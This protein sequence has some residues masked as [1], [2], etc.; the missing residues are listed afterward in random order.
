MIVK[1]NNNEKS[2]IKILIHFNLTPLTKP[3]IMQ[4]K[5]VGMLTYMNVNKAFPKALAQLRNINENGL[6]K[7]SM[8]D[9]SLILRDMIK[10]ED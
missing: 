10:S 6:V 3:Y 1:A 8:I 2:E 7:S 4:I 9:P 5:I